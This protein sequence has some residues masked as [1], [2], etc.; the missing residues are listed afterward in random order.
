MAKVEEMERET[1]WGDVKT[2]AK[3]AQENLSTNEST[4]MNNDLQAT[5]KFEEVGQ[6][7]AGQIGQDFLA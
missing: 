4:N 1:E 7:I 3:Q 2:S 5:S 6:E